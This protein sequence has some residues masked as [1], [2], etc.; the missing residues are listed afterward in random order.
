M[1]INKKL[2]IVTKLSILNRKTF[3]KHNIPVIAKTKEDEFVLIL[4]T[5]DEGCLILNPEECNGVLM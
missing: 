1:C 4:G 3:S 2:W 5:R